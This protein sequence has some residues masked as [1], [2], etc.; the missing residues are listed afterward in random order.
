MLGCTKPRKIRLF[1]LLRLS[2]FISI[3]L[4]TIIQISPSPPKKRIDLMVCPL[5]SSKPR[6]EPCRGT[7][8]ASSRALA[9]RDEARARWEEKRSIATGRERDDYFDEWEQS[10]SNLSFF[11]AKNAILIQRDCGFCLVMET[12]NLKI[13]NVF[14]LY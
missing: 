5:F 8:R 10:S 13:F 2:L 1:S 9:V 11:L 12:R 6:F 4:L 3:Y 14:S 7:A